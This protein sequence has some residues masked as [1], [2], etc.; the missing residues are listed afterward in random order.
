MPTA[1]PTVAVTP[2]R[3]MADLHAL[4]NLVDPDAPGWSRVA[5]TEFENA[6][7]DWVR[8]QMVSVGL[9]THVDGAG[10]VIGRLAGTKPELGS[11]ITG[12]HTDT[13]HGGGRF[14]GIVGLTAALECVRALRESGVRLNHDLVVINFFSEEPNRFGISCIGSRALT[15][16]SSSQDMD[17]IDATGQTFGSALQHAGMDPS[18]VLSS[19]MDFTKVRAFVEL[20]IE[21]GPYLEE[22]GSQI[23]VVSSIT[24]IKRFQ[25]AFHGRADHA[26]TTPMNRRR[27][28]GCAAAASV[29][30]IERI[31]STNIDGRGTTGLVTFAP[32]AVNVVTESAHLWGE[33]R[34]PDL[35]WL[36]DASGEF[37]RAA[38]Q[39]GHTRSVSVELEWLPSESPAVMNDTLGAT[40][41]EQ[42][43]RLGLQ[44]SRLYSGGHYLGDDRRVVLGTAV[45]A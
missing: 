20:H 17:R 22:H 42:A 36:E 43:S 11:I 21:Q 35:S 40:I 26:G 31:A 34:S 16:H 6:G 14:D 38:E 4:S 1:E 3:V 23:G 25:A 13:V 19:Q 15:G 32:E 37:A 45:K 28:A 2:E 41:S 29:L 24:G 5:L 18:A 9:Q 8:Q 33:F 10:N 39:E 44:Q 7:R 27:D 12:S 30:A